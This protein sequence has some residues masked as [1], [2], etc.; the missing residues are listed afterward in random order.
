MLYTRIESSL[1]RLGLTVLFLLFTSQF[2]FAD[3]PKYW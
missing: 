3:E 1:S 2:A